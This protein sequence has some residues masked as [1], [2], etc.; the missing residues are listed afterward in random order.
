MKV[1]LALATGL[2]ALAGGSAALAADGVLDQ[3]NLGMDVGLNGVGYQWQQQITAGLGGRLT[4]IS[5]W[6]GYAA[7]VRIA[8]GD[9]FSTGPFVFSQM[10]DFGPPGTEKLFIDTRAANIVLSAGDTFVID[11]SDAVDGYGAS[12]VPY[13]GGDLWITDPVFY[14]TPFNYTAA[15]G[16]SLRFE[17]YMDA[18]PEPATWAMMIA[19]FGLAGGA[20]RRRAGPQAA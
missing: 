19:G 2:L 11:L 12:S 17:T 5:L 9:A 1:V 7:R 8:K 3:A 16:T 18:V 15:H 4:G 10:V 13:A 6:G 14:T 20:L